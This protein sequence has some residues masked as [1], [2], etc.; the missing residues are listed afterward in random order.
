MGVNE[1][2]RVIVGLDPCLLA[3]GIKFDVRGWTDYDM[4]RRVFYR[5]TWGAEVLAKDTF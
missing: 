3:G 2:F 1:R 4:V 5:E